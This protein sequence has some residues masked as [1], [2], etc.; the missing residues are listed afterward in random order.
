[1]NFAPTF[2][3]FLYQAAVPLDR[4]RLVPHDPTRSVRMLRSCFGAAKSPQSH[5]GTAAPAVMQCSSQIE[6]TH[7]S[8]SFKTSALQPESANIIPC[9]YTFRKRSCG[10]TNQKAWCLRPDREAWSTM[11]LN[12][13]VGSTCESLPKTPLILDSFGETL[14]RLGHRQLPTA[15]QALR[16]LR[17]SASLALS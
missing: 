1:M 9:K 16:S 4:W 11:T 2:E 5:V 14:S 10:G 7:R 12:A 17:A 8:R 3:W 6:R 15:A 13:P